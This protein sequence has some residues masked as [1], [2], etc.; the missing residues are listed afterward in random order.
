MENARNDARW[1][2]LPG[3]VVYTLDNDSDDL[4]RSG[5]SPNL[6]GSEGLLSLD[7]CIS[8]CIWVFI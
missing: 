2:V 6:S 5:E 7:K 1:N 3:D 8:Y 4:V